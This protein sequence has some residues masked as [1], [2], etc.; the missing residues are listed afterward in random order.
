MGR[1]LL[2][3]S[4]S[5]RGIEPTCHKNGV[6][7]YECR[8]TCLHLVQLR[9]CIFL[10]SHSGSMSAYGYD[11]KDLFSCLLRPTD[12]PIPTAPSVSMTRK[13]V[14]IRRRA[15]RKMTFFFIMLE[16]V[17]PPYIYY[18]KGGKPR[19]GSLK[20]NVGPVCEDVPVLS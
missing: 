17:G 5:S 3:C 16:V 1:T 18:R 14:E 12:K 6:K 10:S 7:Y 11:T 19:T 2:G 15:V 9:A 4:S 20:Q 8:I 13:C